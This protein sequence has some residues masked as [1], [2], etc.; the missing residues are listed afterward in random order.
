M[1][2]LSKK[3]D[4]ARTI[5]GISL[6]ILAVVLLKSAD[7][8]TWTPLPA[9]QVTAPADEPAGFRRLSLTDAVGT[10]KK[11]GFYRLQVTR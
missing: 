9:M 2:R 7:L 5:P 4:G 1:S 11:P 6:V 3:S 8:V 10:G